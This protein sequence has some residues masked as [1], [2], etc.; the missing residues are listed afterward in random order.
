MLL[1]PVVNQIKTIQTAGKDEFRKVA[2]V[3]NFAAAR[4]DLKQPPAAYVLPLNDS[5]GANQLGGGAILQPVKERYG[6]ALALSNLRDASGVAAQAELERLRRLVIDKLLGFVPGDGYEPC[7]YGGGTI[8]LMTTDVLW[9]QLVF[10]TGY[11]ERN[12]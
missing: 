6:V 8:L 4:E 5:A 9:W 10:T 2:G 1:I 12:F 11:H 7:E 3:A